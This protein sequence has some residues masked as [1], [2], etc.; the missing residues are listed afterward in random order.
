MDRKLLE[1]LVCPITK[2]PVSILPEPKLTILNEKI[3]KAEV[4][5]HGG[6]VLTEPLSQALITRNG[7]V[8]YPINQNIPVML[9]DESIDTVQLGDW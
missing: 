4:S 3:E 2:Q 7:G 5:N 8:I 1:I 9:E 6:V